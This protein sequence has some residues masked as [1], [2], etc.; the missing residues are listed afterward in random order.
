MTF[1]EDMLAMVNDLQ[2]IPGPDCL[3]IRTNRVFIVQRQFGQSTD[4][5]LGN[6]QDCETEILPRPLIRER[7]MGRELIVKPVHQKFVDIIVGST[8]ESGG[9][10]ADDLNPEDRTQ[11]DII[12]RVQGPNAGEY[13]LKDYTASRPFR[14]TLILR[15][16]PGETGKRLQ[17]PQPQ[18]TSNDA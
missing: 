18:G 12:F 2:D 15:R 17:H 16:M 14:Q 9:F 13:R 7:N 3:D 11:T 10:D 8:T 6:A 4:Y 5:E 1:R